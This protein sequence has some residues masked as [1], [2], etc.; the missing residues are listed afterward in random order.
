MDEHID[1]EGG[2]RDVQPSARSLTH[3]EILAINLAWMHFEGYLSCG[4]RCGRT[5]EQTQMAL[6][7]KVLK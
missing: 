6:K 5:N 3:P 4:L 2:I 7:K 1:N